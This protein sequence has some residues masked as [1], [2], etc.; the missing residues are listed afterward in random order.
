MQQRPSRQRLS[1]NA[2]LVSEASGL[3]P[4]RLI[5]QRNQQPLAL[6][7][8]R[9]AERVM[10]NWKPAQPPKTT[11]LNKPAR[12]VIASVKEPQ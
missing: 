9:V 6:P 12:T 11:P 10:P 3:T 1:S 2:D 8:S 7:D 4:N 5:T